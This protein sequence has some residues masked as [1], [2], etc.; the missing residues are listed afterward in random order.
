MDCIQLNDD[1]GKE[2]T[3]LV[4]AVVSS[5]GQTELASIFNEAENSQYGEEAGAILRSIWEDDTA[6]F[7]SDQV[8]MVCD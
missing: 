1:Q 4:H 6:D 7:F 2:V 5:E 3:Q 8:K